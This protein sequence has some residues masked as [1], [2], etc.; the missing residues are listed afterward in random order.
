MTGV[1]LLPRCRNS[2]AVVPTFAAPTVRRGPVAPNARSRPV[3]RA[4]ASG[5]SGVI[6]RRLGRELHVL[7][8][9]GERVGPEE[10]ATPVV[11]V[12]Q[13]GSMAP[14]NGLAANAISN[15]GEC[16]TRLQK[17]RNRS[18]RSSGALPAIRFALMAPIDVPIIQ[19]GS[20]PLRATPGRRR[21]GRPRAPTAL[22]H[23]NDLTSR[24][25]GVLNFRR[26]KSHSFL[27]GVHVFLP[28]CATQAA[29][30]WQGCAGDRRRSVARKKQ[31]ERPIST[32]ANFFVGLLARRMAHDLSRAMP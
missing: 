27:I 2:A 26:P 1:D 12:V 19:S 22:Q 16:S 3:P 7:A 20:T 24:P 13:F 4:C 5:Q 9:K 25:R 11:T 8:R 10:P 28:Q 29:V 17:A 21:P 6:A 14:R 18:R 30:D 31:R 32:V 15:A 23:E